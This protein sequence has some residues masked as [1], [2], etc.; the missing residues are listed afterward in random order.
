MPVGIS[1]SASARRLPFS[2]RLVIA[3]D[4]SAHQFSKALASSAEM[5][6]ERLATTHSKSTLRARWRRR[7]RA[8]V[9][10]CE[11]SVT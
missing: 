3:H 1:P 7:G 6:P 2:L 5:V 8:S 11:S 9:R 10:R 4:F